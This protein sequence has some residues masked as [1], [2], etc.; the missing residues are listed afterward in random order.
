MKQCSNGHY[1]DSL[2]YNLCPFCQG[3]GPDLN[4]TR[5]K[6]Q[7][8]AVGVDGMKRCFSGHYYNPNKYSSCPYCG[9]HNLDIA[10]TRPMRYD[11]HLP[12][13][14][15]G[16]VQDEGRTVG[17]LCK[18]TGLDP[19]VGWFVCIEGVDR[20]RDYHIHS[21]KNYIGRSEKMDINIIGDNTISRE[22][23]AIVSFNPKNNIF[24]IHPGDGRGLVYLNEEE[25]DSPAELK[26][27]DI[28]ELGQTKLMFVPFC[29][30][31]F[32]WD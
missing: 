26:P 5:A 7:E 11:G 1:Y 6:R 23:H 14:E 29:G 17:L 16:R 10:K 13:K 31:R 22:N 24:K 4:V 20:G 8:Y 9:V 2:I 25:V 27:Y 18:K 32:K 19:V 21:E 30:E 12:E 15:S 28:I 3:Q